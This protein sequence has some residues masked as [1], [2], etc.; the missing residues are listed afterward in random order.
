MQ[1]RDLIPWGRTRPQVPQST[2]EVVSPVFALQRKMNRAFDDF[3]SR[4]DRPF[5]GNGFL[6]VAGPSTDITETDKE[7]EVAIELPG[8]D[9]KDIDV[10]LTRDSLTI[11]G[12]KK[13]EKEQKGAGF[14]LSE[15]S[16]G[17]FYRTIPLP[18]GI[19]PDNA[20]AE[21][22]RGVL[23]I[24]VPKSPEAQSEVKRIEVKAS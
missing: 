4:F 3:W 9:E 11:R 24:T 6:G 10:R 2:G 13:A 14:T 20:R 19:D 17:S 21:Y 18:A 8:I 12:E 5:G 23:T 7:V 1:I 15:R 22:K 16:Y